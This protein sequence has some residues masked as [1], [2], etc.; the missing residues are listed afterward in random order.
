MALRSVASREFVGLILLRPKVNSDRPT[1]RHL[2]GCGDEQQPVAAAHIQN[3][4]ISAQAE[5]AQNSVALPEFA[6][7]AAVQHE[8]PTA[9]AAEP[10]I[11][12]YISENLQPVTAERCGGS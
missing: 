9:E 8:N 12:R 5:T 10:G 6:Q 3:C 1:T 11:E 7:V 2:L 4:F